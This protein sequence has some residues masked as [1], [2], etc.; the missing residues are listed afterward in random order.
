MSRQWGNGTPRAF[1]APIS[2]SGALFSGSGSIIIP[3]RSGAVLM[4]SQEM[5]RFGPLIWRHSADSHCRADQG[6]L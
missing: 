6:V 5:K 1:F 4:D 3:R 2:A